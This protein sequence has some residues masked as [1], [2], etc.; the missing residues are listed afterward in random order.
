MTQVLVTPLQVGA[1]VSARRKTLGFSQANLA[2]RLSL[3]QARYSALEN[4][5][6]RL[7]LDRLL[8]LASALGLELT[9]SEKS[10]STPSSKEEW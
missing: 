8:I 6:D 5:P 9:I 4:N 10:V 2:E 7:T 1:V 3:S